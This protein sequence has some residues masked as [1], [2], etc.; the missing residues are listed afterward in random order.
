MRIQQI[1][2]KYVPL[3]SNMLVPAI[4]YAVSLLSFLI[5]DGF[6]IQTNVFLHYSFYFISAA[7]LLILL[8]FNINR[9]MFFIIG[10]MICYLLINCMKR[11]YGINFNQTLFFN[12]LIILIPL[13]LILSY[14]YGSFR[15]ISS[16]SLQ[17]IMFIL[18]Q[19]GIVDVLVKYNVNLNVTLK[20]INIT[21]VILF[22]VF[23]VLFLIR[24]IKENNLYNYTTL[25]STICVA[26]AIC[27]SNSSMGLSLFF[28]VAQFIM[29][30]DLIFTLTYNHFYDATTGFYSRNSYLIK[31]KSFPFKYNLGIISIDN[32][33]KL[34]KTFGY[35]KQRI[36]TNLIAEVVQELTQEEVVFRYA[37]DQFV[38]LYKDKDNKE[39]FT[40]LDNVRRIIAGLQFSTTAK[41][42][43]IKLTVSCSLAEKKRSDAGALEVL[44]RADKAMRKT[45]KFSHN[46]TSKG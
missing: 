23:I 26:T 11:E 8:N 27:F 13:N 24:S 34:L 25:Y 37:P 18:F 35:K 45:L 42:E 29:M 33:D 5:K 44:M 14:F 39:S 19:Y 4:I 20:G 9:H 30:A 31:S 32:Y 21:S 38:V 43:P 40:H 1:L 15:F 2:E 28:V 3:I 7:S 6:D 16:K 36:L 46:V 22:F 41:E 12:Y 10:N 17:F